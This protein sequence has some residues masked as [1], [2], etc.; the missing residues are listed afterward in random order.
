MLEG[1]P[2]LGIDF[3]GRTGTCSAA[4]IEYLSKTEQLR[5]E[6]SAGD[7]PGFPRPLDADGWPNKANSVAPRG[8]ATGVMGALGKEGVVGGG[9]PA[10]DNAA[11]MSWLSQDAFFSSFIS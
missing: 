3:T 2:S 10:R 11:V 1:L 7:R 6:C 5:L 9:L 8:V 4:A